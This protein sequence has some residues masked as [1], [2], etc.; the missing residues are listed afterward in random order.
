MYVKKKDFME[1]QKY[2][3][4]PIH[5][6]SSKNLTSSETFI[7][8]HIIAI[9]GSSRCLHNCNIFSFMK[10]TNRIFCDIDINS[11]RLTFLELNW[12]FF[13]AIS[14]SNRCEWSSC[15]CNSCW[16]KSYVICCTLQ[17]DFLLSFYNVRSI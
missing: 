12:I 6:W 5:R 14:L 9:L 13:S 8:F 11:T 4:A 7:I 2:F 15:C 16:D 10:F 1:V 17:R 3:S